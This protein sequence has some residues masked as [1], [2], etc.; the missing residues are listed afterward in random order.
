[1]SLRR[2]IWNREIEAQQTKTLSYW[3][4]K[5]VVRPFLISFPWWSDSILVRKN[6][7]S[8]E[9]NIPYWTK[10]FI[11]R[12]IKQVSD[13]TQTYKVILRVWPSDSNYGVLVPP[14]C[15]FQKKFEMYI[16][17]QLPARIAE[18]TLN[19]QSKVDLTFDRFAL[20][21]ELAHITNYDLYKWK[22]LASL[23]VYLLFPGS[24]VPGLIWVIPCILGIKAFERHSEYQADKTAIQNFTND[25]KIRIAEILSG[26]QQPKYSPI[27]NLMRSHPP[28]Y[29]RAARIWKEILFQE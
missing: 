15:L 4:T 11:M 14:S 8:G 19:R 26:M 23:G 6:L 17:S 27:L 9:E 12:E 20:R 29:Q 13:K 2:F 3:I 18:I 22:S 1:M 5:W 16:P 7:T 10:E 28:P 24:G 25:E 21:H